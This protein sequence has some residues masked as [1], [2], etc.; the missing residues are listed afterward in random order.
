MGWFR[1]SRKVPTPTLHLKN[2]SSRDQGILALLLVV[3][4]LAFNTWT[5]ES[6][7]PGGIRL[8]GAGKQGDYSNLTLDGF[9]A[10][11]LYLRAVP[12]PA[13]VN[14]ENPYDPAKRPPGIALADMSYYKGRYYS[15]FGVAPVVTLF[16]PWRLATGQDLPAPYAALFFVNGAF[17]ASAALVWALRRRYFP[18]SGAITLAVGIMAIGLASMTYPVLRRTS[19]WEP[20]VAAG[21]FFSTASLLCLYR[22]FHS[23]RVAAWFAAAGLLMGLAVGSRPT[24]IVGA[25]AFVP[26]VAW[27]WLHRRND[28]GTGG[29]PWWARAAALGA[30]FSAVVAGLF[31]YNFE[32]FGNPLEFGLNYQL[33]GAYEAMVQHFS[34]GYVRFNAYVYYLAPA[35]WSRYFPFVEPVHLPGAPPGYYS[36]E[37]VYGILSNL[38]FS[39][40]ALLAPLALLRRPPGERGT[41]A[42]FAG[43]LAAF[44][45]AVGAFLLL[46]VTST[47]RYMVDFAPVLVLLACVGLLGAERLAPPGWRRSALRS[48][49]VALALFSVGVSA[50]LN[51]QLLD[52]VRQTNP[53]VYRGLSHAFDTP[54]ALAERAAGTRFGPLEMKVRFPTDKTGRIEPLVATGREFETDFLF[55][56][57][58]DRHRLRVGFEHT[59]Y[60]IRWSSP[61]EVDYQSEHTVR[62]AMGSL[63]PPRAHPF[64]D[65]WDGVAYDSLCRQL[66]VEIDGV[67]VLD[68]PQDFYDGSPGALW[69]GRE[70]VGAYGSLFTGSIRDARRGPYSPVRAP[71][72]PRGPVEIEFALPP[73]AGARQVPL[74]AAGDP[75]HADT[76][77]LRTLGHSAVRLYYEHWDE[78]LLASADIT[79]GDRP[80]HTLLVSAPALWSDDAGADP[81]LR[82][83][84]LVSLDGR[85]V[86]YQDVPSFSPRRNG[87]HFGANSGASLLCEPEFPWPIRSVRAVPAGPLPQTDAVPGWAAP[88]DRADLRRGPGEA[89]SFAQGAPF[90]V[91]LG[92]WAALL[93]W[94]AARLAGPGRSGMP[95]ILLRPLAHPARWAWRH[96]GL[97]AACLAAAA[98]AAIILCRREAYLRAAGPVHLRVML[99]QGYWGR[100]QTLVAT[101]RSGAGANFYVSYPD[102]GHVQLGADIWGSNAVSGAVPV[103]YR[104]AQ[105]VVVNASGLYPH[106]HPLLRGLSDGV[107]DRL[108]KT[109]LV[110]LNGKPA[111]LLP[112]SAY[113]SSASEVTLGRTDVGFSNSEHVFAGQ[114]LAAGRL[115]V[116][117]ELRVGRGRNAHLTFRLGP[118]AVGEAQPLLSIGA[119]G[120]QGLCYI[121]PGADPYFRV[122]FVGPDGTPVQ[123]ARFQDSP[124]RVHELDVVPGYV[125]GGTP[126]ASVELTLDGVRV[127]R[128][129]GF[130]PYEDCT[131]VSGFNMASDPS[132]SPLFLGPQ[133]DA[134]ALPDTEPPP[135][136]SS[137]APLLLVLRFPDGRTGSEPL[138]VS[139]VTGAGDFIYVQYLDAGHARF[140]FDHWSVG[141]K[142]GEPVPLD[143]R[144]PHRLEIEA[145]ALSHPEGGAAPFPIRV[146]LDGRVVLEGQSGSYPVA[147]GGVAIGRNPI[148][149]STCG[150]AFSGDMLSAL[151][152]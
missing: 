21:Y 105:D 11:H 6:S 104:E 88:R 34:A 5:L 36:S 120:R 57:Y 70:P 30:P 106:G 121:V 110:A 42:A 151:R 27:A 41:L 141:G 32:R 52:L 64:F 86:A 89:P 78:D 115:P 25:C 134:A 31:A 112:R 84:L 35:Q 20:P 126:R 90:L 13:L 29:P 2:T 60:P 108:R 132:V 113:D 146:V 76:L 133:L 14:A 91:C 65:G 119:G 72:D 147:T 16:L 51:V 68:A 139:G 118:S 77:F 43:S 97:T 8:W 9:M 59:G 50:L 148:G 123:W 58:I 26:P 87:I 93:L 7:T 99:P 44:Y 47:A 144:Q 39:W 83:R 129:K 71:A 17:L 15:Y 81:E 49:A 135:A 111:L 40:F 73:D 152:R 150:P 62:A 24:L 95:L 140:G 130:A 10:G 54:V 143:Y 4:V 131:V 94:T 61:V 28:D 114:I 55:V 138:L 82:G 45:G 117:A 18:E 136:D 142:L 37:Y 46:F 53:A 63:Y 109:T 116:P 48:A 128:P 100:A 137:P 149:G 127:S 98:A 38:P 125:G 69:I 122:G 22:G 124:G 85:V 92:A 67:A 12:P 145:G 74:L 19:I 3:G 96:R 107:L 80:W 79:V 66:R 33:T 23:R 102:R 101:G 56:D 75:G 1:C 103:D